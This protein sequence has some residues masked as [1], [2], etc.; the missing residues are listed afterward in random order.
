MGY[1]R[2]LCGHMYAGVGSEVGR[3]GPSYCW[4]GLSWWMALD[5]RW[6]KNSRNGDEGI[7]DGTGVLL[8][9]SCLELAAGASTSPSSGKEAPRL[10]EKSFL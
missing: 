1:V 10:L 5:S 3:Q 6:G 7:C 4:L 9:D 2:G 8:G